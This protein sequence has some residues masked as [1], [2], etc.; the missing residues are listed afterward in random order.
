MNKQS[1]YTNIR[2][3][4][5]VIT[6]RN[7]FLPFAVYQYLPGVAV[8]QWLPIIRNQ[9]LPIVKNQYL[10]IAGCEEVEHC[11]HSKHPPAFWF[12]LSASKWWSM[13]LN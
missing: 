10:P 1:K 3:D 6:A 9:Y 8:Y 2:W 5:M 11:C 4:K 7:Q 12:G 13:T